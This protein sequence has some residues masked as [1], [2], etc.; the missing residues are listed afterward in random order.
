MSSSAKSLYRTKDPNQVK[1]N[2]AALLWL[3]LYV[4][5]L[6][7]LFG[8]KLKQDSLL[9]RAGAPVDAVE[10]HKSLTVKSWGLA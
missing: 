7:V 9:N 4:L 1:L 8:A 5:L 10:I 2:V 3:V 6:I